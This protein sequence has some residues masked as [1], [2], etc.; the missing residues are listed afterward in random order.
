M[1]ALPPSTWTWISMNS[2]WATFDSCAVASMAAS[3]NFQPHIA[4]GHTGDLKVPGALDVGRQVC[5]HHR[6]RQAERRRRA[7]HHARD[8]CTG[9]ARRPGG[10]AA[11]AGSRS[12][13]GQTRGHEQRAEH[14]GHDHLVTDNPFEGVRSVGQSVSLP[15]L[16][17]KSFFIA[18][19]PAGSRSGL[20]LP[21]RDGPQSFHQQPKRFKLSSGSRARG[22][23]HKERTHVRSGS[24]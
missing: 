21:C 5:P 1:V 12:R 20:A 13:N 2:F 11:G 22:G 19:R 6:D 23:R 16:T 17:D 10:V 24:L 15:G 3:L 18:P 7:A 8:G 14:C 4:C 9:T